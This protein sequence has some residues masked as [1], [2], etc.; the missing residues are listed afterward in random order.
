MMEGW[1]TDKF[2]N[3][4]QYKSGYTWSKEQELKTHE[5]NSVRVLTVTNIQKD[6]DLS[7]ELYLQGVTEKDKK[8]KAV[9]KD[10]CIAVSSN[11]NRKRIGNA[12]FIKDDTDYLFASF[13]TAFKPKYNSE[14][15]PDYFFRWLSSH[16]VQ[17]RITSV[18]EGTTGLGNLDIRYLRNMDIHF[19]EKSEQTA[20]AAMLSKVDEAI[21]AVQASISAAERLKKSLMQNLL[22]GRMK[23]DGTLRK[24]DE[25]YV[26][27]K[28]GRVPVGWEVKA[29]GDK[30]V[31]KI[32]P[33][34]KYKKKEVYDFIPMEAI[35]E[36]FEGVDYV[37]KQVIDN[38]SYTRFKAGD[39]L[40]AK[41]TPCSENGKV[42]Y[43]DHIDSEVG[44]A[45]TEFI[46]FHPTEN[47]DG[48]YVYLLL[49]SGN[50]HRLAIS[51]ME[52]TTGRQRIPWKIFRNRIFVPMPDK[53]EQNKIVEK[54]LVFD[55]KNSYN[56]SKIAVL[57]RL[58][59]SLMQN[60]LTG[61][62]RVKISK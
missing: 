60:L 37:E 36:N 30:D 57:E 34:Y 48:K 24:E 23:P 54:I 40:F 8:E 35:K 22:T 17:E 11:G 18:S 38:G 20:I 15:L 43:I 28:F 47:V 33:V 7:E 10:W 49:S 45:S 42:A 62:V 5:P 25:F 1:K 6:L 59:K 39:I 27:E 53:K 52:G 29:I 13:L 14:I 46:V 21:A 9:S 51:L 56:Y 41:I 50:V 58:K 2:K 61:R 19:P 44:F 32:N 31:C 55:K 26:D 16:N 3:Q 4:I 12:V